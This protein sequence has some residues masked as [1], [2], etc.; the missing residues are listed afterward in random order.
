MLVLEDPKHL[1]V[2][3]G[4]DAGSEHGGGCPVLDVGAG[5]GDF[6][7]C[8]TRE[9]AA[10]EGGIETRQAERQRWRYMRCSAMSLQ[11]GDDIAEI[12]DPYS[13]A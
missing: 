11:L 1:A 3:T 4:Q 13:I 5:A 6:M 12:V 9:T 8:A 2:D 7:Q 10:G